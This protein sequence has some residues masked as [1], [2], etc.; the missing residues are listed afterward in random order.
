MNPRSHRPAPERA[1]RSQLTQL[2]SEQPLLIGSLQERSRRCGK[3]SC[4]C[5]QG[6][7]HRSLYLATSHQGRRVLLYVP[8]VLHET[9]RLWLSNGRRLK[10][11]LQQLHQ[12]QLD[13]LLQRKQ[14]S[15]QRPA[16]P[17]T[18]QPDRCP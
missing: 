8:R 12:I 17:P 10:Q 18:N 9:V 5:N 3:P 16:R 4:R 15:S 1:V 2:I 13:Q 11:Q 14:Q 6:Q 7:R